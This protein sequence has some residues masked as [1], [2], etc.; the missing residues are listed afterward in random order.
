VGT[1]GTDEQVEAR[2]P[3][4]PRDA[5][6]DEAIIAATL[7]L[8]GQGGIAG[9]SIEAVAA[10]AGVG[11][12]TIYRRWPSKE[13]LVLH[14]MLLGTEQPPTPDTGSLRGDLEAYLLDLV[15][16][17]RAF[18]HQDVL[19]HLVG[20]ASYDPAVRSALTEYTRA[21]QAPMRAVLQRAAERGDLPAGTDPDVFIDAVL[22]AINYRRLMTDDPVD[23]AFVRVL[24]ATVL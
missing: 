18:R 7:Q 3:G 24:L 20:A 11:K 2:R 23:A 21:R 15:D 6:A 12:A 5:R 8:L 16:R 1:A 22:G 13:A 14:A 10:T 17:I 19:P 9:V 4:R